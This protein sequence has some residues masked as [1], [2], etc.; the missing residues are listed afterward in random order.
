MCISWESQGA[1]YVRIGRGSLRWWSLGGLKVLYKKIF[2]I[3]YIKGQLEPRFTMV[4]FL[5][6]NIRQFSRK[7][8]TPKQFLLIQNYNAVMLMLFIKPERGSWGRDLLSLLASPQ[9]LAWWVLDKYLLNEWVNFML[10]LQKLCGMVMSYLDPA[11]MVITVKTEIAFW[12]LHCP[13]P[14]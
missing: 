1:P 13:S 9:C 7:K 12:C 4:W 2:L 10:S 11:I 5:I 3:F 14:F 8:L 6:L